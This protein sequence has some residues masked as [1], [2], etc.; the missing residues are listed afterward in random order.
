MRVDVRAA[1][2]GLVVDVDGDG[3]T[4]SWFAVDGATD[5]Y[6]LSVDGRWRTVSGT[7]VH[8]EEYLPGLPYR[9]AVAGVAGGR[10]GPSSQTV[11]NPD[12]NRTPPTIMA[13]STPTTPAPPPAAAL[14]PDPVATDPSP[15]EPSGGAP[16]TEE[17]AGLIVGIDGCGFAADSRVDVTVTVNLQDGDFRRPAVL[18]DDAGRTYLPLADGGGAGA[19]DSTL[20]FSPVP[21]GPPPRLTVI[22]TAL[23]LAG[24]LGG[25]R[26]YVRVDISDGP[27]WG[28]AL[29]TRP[30]TD[31]RW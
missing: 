9:V 7:K 17:G 2:Q 27:R 12:Q 18:L 15:G 20:L 19:D 26:A 14:W 3:M 24:P 22:D 1:P 6:A 13:P 29:C 30:V 10:R 11:V 31:P 16:A 4:V 23:M 8:L 5:G 25:E 28:T 21:G